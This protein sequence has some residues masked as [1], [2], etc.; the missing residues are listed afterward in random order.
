MLGYNINF[1]IAIISL[2]IAS[3]TNPY[4]LSSFDF[5]I[6]FALLMRFSQYHMQ[7]LYNKIKL[8]STIKTYNEKQF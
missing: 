8:I 2:L 6:P 1:T 4:W 3:Y 7:L 5:T